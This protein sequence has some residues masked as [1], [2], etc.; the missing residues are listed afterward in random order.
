MLRFTF[1]ELIKKPIDEVFHF[2]GNYIND[3]YWRKGVTSM[4]YLNAPE[5]NKG[6]KTVEVMKS[7]G[8][9]Y[10]T[11]AEI[12]EYT[13]NKRTAFKSISGPID[14]YGHREFQEVSEGTQFTYSLTLFPV[15][16]KNILF[17][18]FKPLY[19]KQIQDDLKRL[20]EHLEKNS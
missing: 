8:K 14:C 20:K 13:P 17:T 6:A 1:Q 5:S 4:S 10:K 12:V 19:K 9:E 16:L 15:G 2:A 18:F 11:V 7:M 3:I